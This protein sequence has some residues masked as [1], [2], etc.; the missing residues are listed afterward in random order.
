MPLVRRIPKRG[1][2]NHFAL[3]VATVNVGDLER[4]FAGGRGSHAR[5]AARQEAGSSGRFDEL[6]ILG[7]GELTK[8]LKVSRPS[9]QRVGRGEDRAGGRR[10][11]R[12]ARQSRPPWREQARRTVEACQAA[13]QGCGHAS[14]QLIPGL[15]AG[16]ERLARSVNAQNRTDRTMWEKLRV[17]FTIPELRQKI[18][19][20]LLFL[21]I[22]RV[23]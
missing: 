9:V 17:V 5:D 19:L 13:G 18:L 4:L 1:F 7:D 23:G 10:G 6:K 8:K 3:T 20:T 15:P 11:R 16:S 2:H 12:A 14:R 21:A 22:Y